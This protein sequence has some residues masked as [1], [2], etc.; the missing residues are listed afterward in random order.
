MRAIVH[1]L[2]RAPGPRPRWRRVLGVAL[3]ITAGAALGGCPKNPTIV[4]TTVSADQTVPLLTQMNLNLSSSA[5]PGVHVSSSL[6]SPYPGLYDGGLPPFVLPAQFPISVD[7]AYLSGP[8]IVRVDGV[9]NYTGAILA[10]GSTPAQVVPDQQTE[11]SLTLTAVGHCAT[12]G[13]DGST[14]DGGAD[15]HSDTGTGG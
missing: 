11:A 12:D 5:D 3:G 1:R 13:S 10:T 6:V 9:D 15:A 2:G 14:C 8:V 4:L 7:P